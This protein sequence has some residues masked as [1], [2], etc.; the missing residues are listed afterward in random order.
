MICHPGW[1]QSGAVFDHHQLQVIKVKFKV[2][3]YQISNWFVASASARKY[4]III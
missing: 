4:I 3:K 1:C 2:L